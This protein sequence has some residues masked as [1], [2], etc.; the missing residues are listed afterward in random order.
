[1]ENIFVE[2][3]PPWVETGLQPAFY[4]KE[5]GTVLQQTAR[6]YAR[7]N[8]LIRMF[9][10]LSKNTKEEVERFEG[11][12]NDEIERFEGNVNTEIETFE[13]NVN[14][15]VDDYIERFTTLYNY[16]HDYFDNLDVQNEINH[17][18]DEMAGDGTLGE[19]IDTAYNIYYK[20][21]TLIGKFYQK[22][23]GNKN[24]VINCQGDSLTYGQDTVS[25]DKRPADSTPADDGTPHTNTRASVTYPE[26]LQADFDEVLGSG[27]VTV[28]NL[29][30]SGDTAKMSYNR[31]TVN[32]EADLALIMLG[33]NDSR[34]GA[35]WVPASYRNNISEYFEYLGYIIERYLDWNTAVILVTPP[36]FKEQSGDDMN[37]NNTTR[38]Y[39]DALKM[40]AK[41]YNCPVVEASNNI[42]ADFDEV[43]YSDTIHFNGT[44]YK[45]FADRLF[46]IF[47][48]TGIINPAFN[49]T[50]EHLINSSVNNPYMFG[51]HTSLMNAPAA[52]NQTSNNKISYLTNGGR[53][54]YGC[55]IQYENAIVIPVSTYSNNTAFT[56]DFG[57]TQPLTSIKY[58][59][60][61]VSYKNSIS[62]FDMDTART[63]ARL[64]EYILEAIRNNNYMMISSKGYHTI[65][66]KNSHSTNV[67]FNGFIIIPLEEVSKY[68]NK[69]VFSLYETTL[70]DNEFKIPLNLIN[71][72]MWTNLVDARNGGGRWSISPILDINIFSGGG[73]VSYKI[74]LPLNN[75]EAPIDASRIS[76]INSGLVELMKYYDFDFADT[77]HGVKSTL[78]TVE[79]DDTD[80]I[81]TFDDYNTSNT[82]VSIN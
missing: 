27:K 59:N 31:W 81:L 7:V 78:A 63:P 53:I 28:N 24:L 6:M 61:G 64:R 33:T 57:S 74:N 55:N 34:E 48:G 19:A 5:S 71:M 10:R 30:F 13:R 18:L 75:A 36:T 72:L 60:N 42:T 22:L 32:R 62:T 38:V 76:L 2:F 3:L 16:V 70:Q 43:F 46:A 54:C 8:M 37:G 45:A 21:V 50:T 77:S 47:C 15:T 56:V 49:L 68:L 52:N 4:D 44:G 67:Y 41:K 39:D 17:K 11:V 69:V 65:Q 9:N 26:E 58:T 40:F 1:M 51:V 25:A 79:V 23:C 73:L 29:G 14:G 80:L 66:V 82:S 12:V 20:N 35:S